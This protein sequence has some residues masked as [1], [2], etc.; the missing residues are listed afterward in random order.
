MLD[1][2]Q[3]LQRE[4]E[5]VTV[6]SQEELE[7]FRNTYLVKKGTINQLFESFRDVANDQKKMIGQELNKLKEFAQSRFQQFQDQLQPADHAPSQ[8]GFD[9]TL[10]SIQGKL[11][12]QH[13]L[14][15]VRNRIIEIF[16]RIGFNTSDG[17]EIEDDW[18]N[19]T[20]LN[21]PPD[22]PA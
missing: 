8:S 19:F 6:A 20:A 13:P 2:I 14:T 16:E 9:Y 11:G 15:L 4:I 12:T 5:K 3:A 1:R 17:P 18:H 22:H 21:F 10:P 7:S